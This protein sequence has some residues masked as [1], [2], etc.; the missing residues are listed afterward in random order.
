M[1]EMLQMLFDTLKEIGALI[2]ADVVGT[3][4]K[5]RGGRCAA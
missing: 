3:Y 1:N 5:C 4:W 2:V